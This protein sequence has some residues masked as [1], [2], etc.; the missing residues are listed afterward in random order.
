MARL[1]KE[2]S[3]IDGRDHNLSF[4]VVVTELALEEVRS[5]TLRFDDFKYELSVK[6]FTLAR[7]DIKYEV[8]V[9]QISGVGFHRRSF[10]LLTVDFKLSSAGKNVNLLRHEEAIRCIE[11]IPMLIDFC[12]SSRLLSRLTVS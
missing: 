11:G 12:S 4:F 3:R 6:G 5:F 2:V 1:L 10:V 8:F 9:D 7:L